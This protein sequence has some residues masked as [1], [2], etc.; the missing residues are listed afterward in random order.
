MP[1]GTAAEMLL[2][3]VL[4]RSRLRGAVGNTIS[5]AVTAAASALAA[6]S[7]AVTGNAIT[8]TPGG[9][10]RM[11]IT[12]PE[13]MGSYLAARIR[14]RGDSAG[15]SY[16]GTDSYVHQGFGVSSQ[17]IGT[18]SLVYAPTGETAGMWV[19][20]ILGLYEA[21]KTST[22]S[23]PD[24]LTAWTII[25]GSGQPTIISGITDATG[26]LQA[27]SAAPASGLVTAVATGDESTLA[28]PSNAVY[29]S[30]GTDRGAAQLAVTTKV[31][32]AARTP[33]AW[34]NAITF[35]VS[36]TADPSVM[37]PYPSARVTS[38]QVVGMA[39]TVNYYPTQSALSAAAVA[40]AL[41]GDA[42]AAE[43]VYALIDHGQAPPGGVNLILNPIWP[44]AATPLTGGVD[45]LAPL[46]SYVPPVAGTPPAPAPVFAYPNLTPG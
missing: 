14:H 29:L 37:A 42:A 35:R 18:V 24:G 5:V 41:A 2:G 10:G 40:E 6:S 23:S 46:A 17:P 7:A 27:L 9:R 33:G 13:G 15:R 31:K 3:A 1:E 11:Y 44:S 16:W 20:R 39:I 12:G 19:L 26:I 25:Q 38:V 45:A 22:A 21:R 4:I 36:S 30:G 32:I 34:G 8:V 43:L 28:A